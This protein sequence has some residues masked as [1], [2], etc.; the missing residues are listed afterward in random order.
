MGANDASPRGGDGPLRRSVFRIP[1]MDCPAEEQMIRLKLAEAPVAAL[2][3]DLAA[4]TLAVDHGG[5][6][7]IIL[8]RL[9][10]L[11]LGAELAESRPLAVAATADDADQSLVLW[12]VLAINAAMFVVELVAGWWAGSA[13]LIADAMDMLADAVVYGLALY[14]V[15]RSNAHKLRAARAAGWLQ[16]ALAAWAL[17]ETGRRMA[18]GS[19]PENLTMVAIA[20]LALVANLTC[21]LLIA[22]YREAA[23][24]LRASYLFTANDVLANLGVIVA[25][26]LVGWTGESWPDWLVGAL[27]GAMVLAGA[28]RILRLR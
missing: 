12:S 2:R 11:K 19:A 23:V 21:L 4:R 9:Q 8:D 6:A 17:A 25:G 15:G 28:L 3:F 14:A 1:G 18:A 13:G 26:V 20:L 22:K 10:A 27:I 7:Q 16:L 24:H 5:E